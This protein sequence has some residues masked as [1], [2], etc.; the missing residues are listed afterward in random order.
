MLVTV[1]TMVCGDCT[2]LVDVITVVHAFDPDDRAELESKLSRCPDCGGT[3]L[4]TW[5][6]DGSA[7]DP[8][9]RVVLGPCPKCGASVSDLVSFGIWD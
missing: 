1:Q 9:A 4:T 5:G 2:E 8:D 3:R 6:V 7:A